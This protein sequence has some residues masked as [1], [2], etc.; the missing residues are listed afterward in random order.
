V[1]YPER[2]IRGVNFKSGVEWNGQGV[3]KRQVAMR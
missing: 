3:A 2:V 1:S